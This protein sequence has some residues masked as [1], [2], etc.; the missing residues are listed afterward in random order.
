[1]WKHSALHSSWLRAG[2]ASLG[3]DSKCRVLSIGKLDFPHEGDSRVY[4][5]HSG[6]VC[7]MILHVLILTTCKVK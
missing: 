4:I 7:I 6:T 5:E 1:V 3:W 2:D